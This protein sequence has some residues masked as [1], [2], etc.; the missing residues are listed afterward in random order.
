ML[1]FVKGYRSTKATYGAWVVLPVEE[2]ERRE[3]QRRV[4]RGLRL[5]I[6][7]DQCGEGSRWFRSVT[8]GQ[9]AQRNGFITPVKGRPTHVYVL[10]ELSP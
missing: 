2:W 4:W 3:V 6:L 7:R 10:L 5:M 1:G 8:W 9:K